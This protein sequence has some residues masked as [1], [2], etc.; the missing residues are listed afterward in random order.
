MFEYYLD[1]FEWDQTLQARGVHVEENPTESMLEITNDASTV[2]SIGEPNNFYCPA[3]N[4]LSKSNV[5]FAKWAVRMDHIREEWEEMYFSFGYV[6]YPQ[7]D[8][9]NMSND[10]KWNY[11]LGNEKL[12]Q[13]ALNYFYSSTEH[14]SDEG[15]DRWALC[16]N[17][18]DQVGR[19][20]LSKKCDD[21]VMKEGDVLEIHF[22]FDKM[23]SSLYYNG[24][25]ITVL[26]KNIPSVLVP[27]VTWVEDTQI[28]TIKWEL[29][30]KKVKLS[31]SKP[32]Y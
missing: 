7:H 30:Y 16:G 32:L 23:E 6:K 10:K 11:W 9:S 13:S 26:Y 8:P 24:E 12:N 5:S 1:A 18:E 4:V 27:A 25:F 15:F 17:A 22:D 28:S 20:L 31:V 3:V 14:Y 29:T 21:K 19:E 2:K